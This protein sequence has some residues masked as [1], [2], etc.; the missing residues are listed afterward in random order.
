MFDDTRY[1]LRAL[2]NAPGYTLA[3]VITIA[4]GIAASTA[5]FSM[6][7]GVL[8]RR[9]PI[10]VGDRFVHLTQ[11]STQ[12][13]DEGFSVREVLDLSADTQTMNGVAEYHSMSFQLYGYGEPLR[14]QTSVVSD[15]FFDLLGVRPILGRTFRP[16]EEAVGAPPVV[17]LTH[18]FW[19]NQFHG[20]PSIIGAK[21]TMNDKVHTVVGVLPS[22]PGYPNDA[23]MFMPAGACP[24]RS[25]PV[26][27]KDYGMRMVAAFAVL[28]PGVSV[29]RAR[30]E[31][32][33]LAARN[34]SAHPE[35]YPKQQRLHYAATL[36]RDEMTARAKPILLLLFATAAFLL[37]AAVANVANL[38]LSRQMHRARE[39][40]VRVA[41]GAPRTRIYRQLALESLYV[42]LTGGAVG[43]ALAASSVGLLR[44]TAT[45]FTPRADEIQMSASVYLFALVLCV[46]TALV[47][48]AVPFIQWARGRNV[49]DALRQ[50][51]TGAMATRGDHRLR[52]TLV[53]AQVALAFVMLVGAGLIS[54]S[55]VALTRVDA[56]IEVR[57]VLTA[58]LTLNFTKYNANQLTRN[59][60]G[61]LLDRLNGMPG[62]SSVALASTLPLGAQGVNSNF[63]FQIEGMTSGTSAG[64]PRSDASSVSPDYFRTIGVP[65]LRGR[66]FTTADRDTNTPP[67]II[68]QRLAKSYWGSRD[69]IG[70]RISPDS[71]RHWLT[72]VGIVGD[73]RMTGLD[74]DVTDEVYVPLLSTGSGD[75]RVFLRT[76]GVIPPVVNALRAAV[77]EIDAQQPV[78]AVQ[79]LEQVRGAQLAEPRLTAALLIVFS[80]VALVLTATGLAGVIGYGV[81]QRLPEIA[82]RIALGATASRVLMLVMRQGMAIV[83]IGL[84]V[85]LAVALEGSS[86][87][88]KLL[89]HVAP[90]DVLTY[91]G[92][93]LVILATAALA[94]FVPSRRALRADPSRVFRAGA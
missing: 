76:T 94:C 5:I 93:G 82:I 13:E 20:D 70:T 44:A 22:M 77:H 29:E 45:R 73:V 43:V 64:M 26:M 79:T 57:N 55:L 47:V 67:A 9:L 68:S 37:L 63:R 48:A 3:A 49:A 60:A 11:P 6:V 85:G 53:V 83:V 58:R 59:F 87:V 52:N 62:T 4:L 36:A 72:I 50:G 51:N 61:E 10:G 56:G 14:V 54:R 71:G 31:L 80:I 19:M 81:T 2:R 16:G 21:F 15:K 38:T 84:V 92:V 65:L 12:N 33:T 23:D 28:R 18:K 34:H 88:T 39:M 7:N 17:V 40:A 25:A 69:P 41:L 91:G 42:S 30:V 74:K 27:L 35:A 86:L 78:S 90:T 24:F 75:L 8:L 32:A 1:A 46:A 89:F 66:D